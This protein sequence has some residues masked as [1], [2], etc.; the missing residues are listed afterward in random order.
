MIKK[1]LILLLILLPIASAQDISLDIFKDTYHQHETLQAETFINLTLADKIT[2]SN[3]ALIN[4]GNETIP[5]SIFLE[6]ISKNHFFVYFN[7]PKLDNGTYYFL[8][9]DIKYTDN[10]LKK[11]SKSKE[12]YLD[13][14]DSF[15]IYP[16]IFNRLNSTILRMTNYGNPINITLSAEE[17]NLSKDFLLNDIFSIALDI[18]KD[19]NDFSLRI[20]YGNEHY[21]IPVITYKQ[22]NNTEEEVKPIIIVKP[23]KN[24]IILLNST[25]GDYFNKKLTLKK[26]SSPKGPFYVK[27]E[28][29]Y[30]INNVRFEL[31]DNLNEI[32]RLN[33]TYISEI[34]PNETVTQY[35]WLNENQ[36]PVKEKYSGNIEVTYNDD[37]IILPLEITFLEE[38]LNPE[39]I[40]KDEIIINKTFTNKTE[41][42]TIKEEKQDKNPV[43]LFTS[44]IIIIL[45]I[46]IY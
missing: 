21:L 4:K 23:Q 44:L 27:N 31:T 2:A 40:T 41:S 43:I 13:K 7:I 3:F 29:N 39:N 33:F 30:K 18:Q 36:S 5:V 9:K 24:A 26:Y 42:S 19:T 35:I 20:D 8:V 45:I 17:I 10:I 6:E 22:I 32:A 38:K 12:F 28:G 14:V 25:F 1:T 16:G 34:Q 11:T 37:K 46:F 15:S